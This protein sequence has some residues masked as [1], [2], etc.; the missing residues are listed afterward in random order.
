MLVFFTFTG[1]VYGKAYPMLEEIC[2]YDGE[3]WTYVACE[4][5][6]E[7]TKTKIEQLVE[8]RIEQLSADVL[9]TFYERVIDYA[10]PWINPY[11]KETTDK[12][13]LVRETVQHTVEKSMKEKESRQLCDERGCVPIPYW[14]TLSE[15]GACT[16]ADLLADKNGTESIVWKDASGKV[17]AEEWS[18]DYFYGNSYDSSLIEILSWNGVFEWEI[19]EE[20]L[21]YWQL[22]YTI[23]VSS[24]TKKVPSQAPCTMN[25][26]SMFYVAGIFSQDIWNWDV[27]NVKKMSHMF[28]G[29]MQFN[30]NIGDWD[31]GNVEDMSWMFY[32]L[33]NFNQ[34]IWDW[35]VSNVEKMLY[36][37]SRAISFNQDIWDW[38]VS[39]VENMWW[40]FH[41]ALNFNQDIWDWDVSNVEKM[42][43]I[44]GFGI[45][46]WQGL[47]W[48]IS[49]NCEY[50][51]RYP[52]CPGKE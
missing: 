21:Y 40:M 51:P 29:A 39:N 46:N 30:Q 12:K 25:M 28:D 9:P 27:S 5:Q 20:N 43:S 23:K 49:F 14:M 33:H 3:L 4:E 38:D 47:T 22:I 44:F 37:F 41:H 19:E 7:E 13:R 16:P 26:N 48:E 52:L 8:K 1:I 11:N 35:D 24:M 6:Y 10:H 15:D 34:D 42:S 31:V 18:I 36:M 45:D 32:N 17:H 2:T 50:S